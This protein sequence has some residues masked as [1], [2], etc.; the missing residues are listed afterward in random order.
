[1][2]LELGPRPLEQSARGTELLRFAFDGSLV[3]PHDIR[4]LATIDACFDLVTIQTEFPLDV[5]SV[6]AASQWARFIHEAGACFPIQKGTDDRS[7][8]NQLRANGS[9]LRYFPGF[10]LEGSATPERSSSHSGR[11]HLRNRSEV[12]TAIIAALATK[13]IA[14]VRPNSGDAAID[15]LLNCDEFR[16]HLPVELQSNLH[17]TR[18]VRLAGDDTEH[19]A[20]QVR[21]ARAED[22][23]IQDVERLAAQ[24]DANV[25]GNAEALGEADVFVLIP[26][27]AN[28]RIVLGGVAEDVRRLRRELDS[29]ASGNDRRSGSNLSPLIGARQLS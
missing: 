13:P 27:A 11:R 8:T 7:G 6:R 21:V 3:S 4:K 17:L 15:G 14:A 20:I 26:E 10:R 2:R 28:L 9:G 1:M 22:R 18:A 5:E 23:P 19:V 16:Q 12:A 29:P 25:F 24:V